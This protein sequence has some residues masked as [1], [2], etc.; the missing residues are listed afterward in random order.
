MLGSVG[1]WWWCWQFLVM[2]WGCARGVRMAADGSESS[3]WL[4][5][6][7]AC[8]HG[9]LDEVVRLLEADP[10][11]LDSCRDASGATALWNAVWKGHAK[12]C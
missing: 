9:N 8:Q 3:D 5:L 4:P 7:A 12:L 2:T 1:R 11:Q 10:P 6:I